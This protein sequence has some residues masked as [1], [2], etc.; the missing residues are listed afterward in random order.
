MD[1]MS[2]LPTIKCSSCAADIDI[3]HLADHVCIT[4]APST[5][6]VPEPMSPTSTISTASPSSI[7]S[8]K[9]NRAATFQGPTFSNRS[10]RPVP[11]GRMPPPPRI[12]SNAANKPFRP[13]EPSP[14]SSQS[15]PR[16]RTPGLAPPKS[17]FKMTRSVTT[18][19]ARTM[20][21]PSP[22]LTSNLDSPF[23]RFPPKNAAPS[24]PNP[25]PRQRLDPYPQDY[26]QPNAL[27]A[28][29][30]P[31]CNGGENISKRLENI[32]PG[33]FDRRPSMT[34]QVAEDN[35]AFEHKRTPTN[36]SIGSAR[37]LPRRNGSVASN[38]SHT[39]AYSS[40]SIGLPSHPKS[41]MG[42]ANA[43]S[44]LPST[45]EQIEGIDDFL[46]R[47]QKESQPS[48]TAREN[49]T[50]QDSREPPV[51]PRRPSTKDLPSAGMSDLDT[52]EFMS[53]PSTMFPSRGSSRSGSESDMPR[54][55]APSHALRPAP[56]GA[57]GL[58]DMPLN[59]LH[60]PSDSGFSDDSYG[61]GFRSIASS[62]SSPP[63]SEAAHSRQ[64]SKISR[65]DFVDEEPM[66]P[67]LRSAS[68]E[69]Y[70]EGR[71]V[72]APRSYMGSDGSRP[73]PRALSPGWRQPTFPPGGHAKYPESPLDPAVQMGAISPRTRDISPARDPAEVSGSESIPM[74]TY[75]P[76][77]AEVRRPS[78]TSKGICRGCSEPIIGKSVKDSSGRLTGRYHKHCFVC[79]TCSDPFP[80]AEFY[81]YENSPYCEHHYHK[82][83]G[84]LCSTCNHGIEG[85]YLETDT[86]QKF[87]PKCFTCTTCRIVLRDGYFEVSGRRYC[88]R[89]AQSAAAPPRS[90]L[91]PG[92]YQ[93]RN[94]QKRG[95]RLMMMA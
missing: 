71:P 80:T 65:S 45:S 53:L 20:G 67:V 18:P 31:R 86:R 19:N 5:T 59:A 60:T 61:S 68:P 55:L 33:P 8:P 50:R 58:N 9:L 66:E 16:S 73:I 56:L 92:N 90:R 39:S 15:D 74:A 24:S 7:V 11:T 44:P 6:A 69:S 14:M 13:L 89:H 91:G 88:E 36:G 85:Q 78:K 52:Q 63:E 94:L 1:R 95:T 12:D 84:S 4:A 54:G 43:Q 47:L 77:Q 35:Q 34:R 83:N 48:T 46:D 62:R 82:L 2:T 49:S 93:P 40:R 70:A 37:S 79:R 23:P 75:E 76:Y 26:A 30:S 17:P 57:S 29:L 28:P 41:G 64:V 25:Q 42:S 3:L 87:H 72:R 51:R 21:P 22:G 81:V 32:A 10:D 38:A 27:F